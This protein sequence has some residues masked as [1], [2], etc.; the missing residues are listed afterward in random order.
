MHT[1]NPILIV[2]DGGSTGGDRRAGLFSYVLQVISN[3]HVAEE[4][5][6]DLYVKFTNNP[7]TEEKG[8]NTWDYYFTQP[9]GITE[10]Q[11]SQYIGYL[12]DDW[13]FG[14]LK[15]G[16]PI[17]TKEV[18]TRTQELVSKYIFPKPHI[19]SKKDRFIS[20]YIQT[21]NYASIH[22]RGTDHIIDA[23]TLN[24]QI[25]VD[26]IQ[27]IFNSYE[28]ILVCSDEQP[29]VDEVKMLFGAN[30]IVSYPSIRST[31]K[32]PIHHN[33]IGQKYQTGE[34]VLIE[35]LLMSQSKYLIRTVSN[36]TH[37]AIFNNK[38]LQYKHIDDLN[39][40]TKFIC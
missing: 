2:S 4:C 27:N 28:K 8:S 32:I 33:N 20:D 10:S 16:N 7:Y 31:S 13:F 30:K 25:Y 23:P 37:F 5:G 38:H 18:I 40:Y 21:D 14:N 11:V 26:N 12:K 3:L 9:F 29:F 36:V 19:L 6:M 35:S 1:N 39:L 34:D 24:K 17:L 22:F 15:C